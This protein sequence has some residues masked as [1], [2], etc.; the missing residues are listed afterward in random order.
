MAV[1][2]NKSLTEVIIM[3]WGN[4]TPTFSAASTSNFQGSESQFHLLPDQAYWPGQ[5]QQPK[6]S[7]EQAAKLLLEGLNNLGYDQQSRTP[8]LK[9]VIEK[10]NAMAKT[11][12]NRLVLAEQ[13]NFATRFPKLDQWIV[14]KL[15]FLSHKQLIVFAFASRHFNQYS[16]ARE[17]NQSSLE[18]TRIEFFRHYFSQEGLTAGLEKLDLLRSCEIIHQN[19]MFQLDD[20]GTDLLDHLEPITATG[21]SLDLSNFNFPVALRIVGENPTIWKR[22]A[23]S[24]GAHFDLEYIRR[25]EDE[26]LN[27]I[28][29][30]MLTFLNDFALRG[31]E[32]SV[33]I[34]HLE[35]GTVGRS[36]LAK[37][38]TMALQNS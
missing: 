17:N 2:I 31:Y 7:I 24:I 25:I 15:S 6:V 3:I 26:C 5:S 38:L 37:K 14:N 20:V 12:A 11:P 16:E 13:D 19:Q 22:L 29:K 35:S 28:K 30:A 32:T 10:H 9:R 4:N 34:K 33:L 18:K 1:H 21:E 36:D 27:D 23:L 8:V